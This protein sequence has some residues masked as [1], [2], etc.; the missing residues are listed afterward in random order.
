MPGRRVR[1]TRC[2]CL[3][4]KPGKE[5]VEPTP[6]QESRYEGEQRGMRG[7]WG[8]AAVALV[9][10]LPLQ[11]RKAKDGERRGESPGSSPAL[12]PSLFY[13]WD[14]LLGGFQRPASGKG[15]GSHSLGT[16]GNWN[17]FFSSCHRVINVEAELSL[18]P[19]VSNVEAELSLPPRVSN[20]EAE[21]ILPRRFVSVETQVSLPLAPSSD[22]APEQPVAECHRAQ[23]DAGMIFSLACTLAVCLWNWLQH[24]HPFARLKTSLENQRF[25]A[26]LENRFL[27]LLVVLLVGIYCGTLLSAWRMQAKAGTEEDDKGA[28]EMSF[29]VNMMNSDWALK[30]LGATIDMKRTSP[31]YRCGWKW[32]YSLLLNRRCTEDEP[33]TILQMDVSQG[34][35]WCFPG[36]SGHVVI[37][38]PARVH[39]TAIAVQHIVEEDSLSVAASS[40]PKGLAV[41]DLLWPKPLLG[42]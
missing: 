7:E 26:A 16:V 18:P 39:L 22:T 38:L 6:C 41:Y 40:A 34:K 29:H 19:R 5:V 9:P 12:L 1:A 23:E 42:S 27:V 25:K 24:T 20:V 31:T 33:D 8:W 30:S 4:W 35:R 28:L 32:G 3:N 17:L 2:Q 10:L 13:S 14:V 21:V 36:H 11:T 37:R 15:L